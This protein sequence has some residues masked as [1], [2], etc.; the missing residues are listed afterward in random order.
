METCSLIDAAISGDRPWKQIGDKLSKLPADS[1]GAQRLVIAY[2]DGSCEPWMTAFLLGCVGDATGYETAQ[3]ILVSDAGSL[4]GSYASVAM[5]KMRDLEAYPDLL[6]IL[7][8]DHRRRVRNDAVYGMAT[9]SPPHLLDDLYNAFSEGRLSRQFASWR[10]AYCEPSDDWLVTVLNSNEI[11][12]R[13]LGCAVI[14]AM[15]RDNTPMPNPGFSVTAPVKLCLEASEHTMSSS[16]RK[17]LLE[18]IEQAC[19]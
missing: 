8:V 16:R 7:N 4:S 18:W 14:D 3:E 17:L 15:L 1:D 10:I 5:A 9:L 2:R 6:K 12:D 13:K 19:A 11:N